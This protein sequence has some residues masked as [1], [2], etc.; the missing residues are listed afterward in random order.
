MCLGQSFIPLSCSQYFMYFSGAL[1]RFCRKLDVDSCSIVQFLT[2][3]NTRCTKHVHTK[4]QCNSKWLRLA[5]L[6]GLHFSATVVASHGIYC[7]FLYYFS[8]ISFLQRCVSFYLCYDI[9]IAIYLCH[10]N[11]LCYR[12][13]MMDHQQAVLILKEDGNGR[14]VY[15]LAPDT[16]KRYFFVL[17]LGLL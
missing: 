6:P 8:L 16:R 12:A 11:I 5:G 3:R 9:W 15:T 2:L 17:C 10:W 4:E 13:C 1:P 14:K 7:M